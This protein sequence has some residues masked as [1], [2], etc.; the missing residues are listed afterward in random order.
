MSFQRISVNE[1]RQ[2]MAERGDVQV[3]DIRD[4]QSYGSGHIENA[5]HIHNDN[6]AEF[7]ESADSSAPLLVCCYHGNMSQQAA[8]FFAEQGFASSYSLDGGYEAWAESEA[9]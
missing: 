3:I 2:L 4:L 6:V 9:G 5:R 8:A 7:L 1:A